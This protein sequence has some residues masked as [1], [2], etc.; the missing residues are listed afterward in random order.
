MDE[1]CARGVGRTRG[2]GGGA[3]GHRDIGE[4]P[5]FG[6]REFGARTGEEAAVGVVLREVGRIGEQPLQQ[7]HYQAHDHQGGREACLL[8]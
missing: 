5:G 6:A 4:N 3:V 2:A 7:C 8:G 1:G